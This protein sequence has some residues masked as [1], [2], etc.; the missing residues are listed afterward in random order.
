MREIRLERGRLDVWRA[1]QLNKYQRAG[2][3]RNQAGELVQYVETPILLVNPEKRKRIE[4]LS[5]KVLNGGLL[6]YLKK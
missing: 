2:L 4:F 1:G 6:D 5:G 3:T